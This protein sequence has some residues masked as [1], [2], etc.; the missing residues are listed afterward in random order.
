[1]SASYIPSRGERVEQTRYGIRRVGT[2]C[3]ADQLQ[4]L[5]GW[6]DGSSSSLPLAR[7]ELR[8]LAKETDSGEPVETADDLVA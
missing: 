3:Y 1:V 4:V 8:V 2:V 7:A 6:D 5:V